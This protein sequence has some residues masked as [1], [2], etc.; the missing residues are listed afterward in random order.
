MNMIGAPKHVPKAIDAGVDIICAQGGEGGGHTGEVATSILIPK[1]VDMCR[2]KMSPLTGEQIQVV[3]AGGIFDGRSLAMALALGAS[4][5]WVVTRFVAA[6]EAGAPPRH[7][8]GVVEA[9]YHDTVR[10]IIFTGRPM[11]VLKT[12]YIMDWEDNKQDQ[13]K[14]LTSGG[15][16]PAIWDAEQREKAGNPMGFKERMEMMPLL[17]GQVAGA[18]TDVQPA[19]QIMSEMVNGC[20]ETLRNTTSAVTSISKL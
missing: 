1:V 17:M 19:A 9:G 2:G 18:I 6:K 13:I 3:A 14:D 4:A 16:L 10:T 12:D 7:Q 20:I 5:V 15:T 8:K 11:R